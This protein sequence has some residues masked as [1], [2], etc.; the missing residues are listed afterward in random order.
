M[1]HVA[2]SWV[3]VGGK[4]ALYFQ[5]RCQGA[6]FLRSSVTH[7]GIFVE[8]PACS[9]YRGALTY[10]RLAQPQPNPH[11]TPPKNLLPSSEAYQSLL[12]EGAIKEHSWS[13]ATGPFFSVEV[14]HPAQTPKNFWAP[15]LL[16]PIERPVQ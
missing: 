2:M 5:H 3:V 13:R 11:I 10:L 12:A 15:V 7:F 4:S 9:R 16:G 8:P 1:K 6:D 14:A